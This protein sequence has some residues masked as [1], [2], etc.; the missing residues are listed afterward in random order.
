V[1]V[2]V[3]GRSSVWELKALIERSI[4]GR[5]IKAKWMTLMLGPVV[6][7]DTLALHDAGIVDGAVLS[8]I[9]APKYKLLVGT[10]PGT[11]ELWNEQ[12]KLEGTFLTPTCHQVNAE[13][14]PADMWPPETW[15]VDISPGNTLVLSRNWDAAFLWRVDTKKRLFC[16]S[17]GDFL[18]SVAANWTSGTVLTVCTDHE[19]VLWS[20]GSGKCIRSVQLGLDGNITVA[21][22]DRGILVL[23]T[24]LDRFALW[25]LEESRDPVWGCPYR[26]TLDV[27]L[28]FSACGNWFYT[29]GG[30][31]KGLAHVVDVWGVSRRSH[32]R[33]LKDPTGS[34]GDASISSDG[35][36]VLTMS[37]HYAVRVWSLGH[38]WAL[39][40]LHHQNRI[41]DFAF[42][43]DGA[44]VVTISRGDA[45][46]WIVDGKTRGRHFPLSQVARAHFAPDG[47]CMLVSQLHGIAMWSAFGA[48]L[49]WA[50]VEKHVTHVVFSH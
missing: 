48:E 16:F 38:D 14:F 46:L 3:S 18:V 1:T 37:P 27:D 6:L 10:H 13:L 44:Q 36:H 2:L 29:I 12:G 26:C 7:T 41:D 8:T 11:I 5:C 23:H 45:W 30:Y 28:G 21:I 42:S 9:I 32:Y 50:D 4:L 34:I 31:G 19:V 40:T 49:C 15:P 24:C 17:H 43:P 39:Y 22:T 35:W 20:I 33:Q 47:K 25:N